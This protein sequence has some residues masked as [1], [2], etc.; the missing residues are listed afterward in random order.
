MQGL[1]GKGIH[2]TLGRHKIHSGIKSFPI[3]LHSAPLT[4]HTAI[5]Q[6]IMLG[7]DQ[8]ATKD[9]IRAILAEFSQVFDQKLSNTKE[10][11]LALQLKTTSSLTQKLKDSTKA[12]WRRGG[13]HRQLEFNQ[14]VSG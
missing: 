9:D 6:P 1:Q 13:N 7:D 2:F 5:P 3:I 10:E 14:Q 11:V 4:L 8:P 12:K